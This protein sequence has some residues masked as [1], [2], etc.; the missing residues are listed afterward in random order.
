MFNKTEGVLD[1]LIFF[2]K[3]NILEYVNFNWFIGIT[4][5]YLSHR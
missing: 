4:K 5:F 3:T 1:W 2:Y